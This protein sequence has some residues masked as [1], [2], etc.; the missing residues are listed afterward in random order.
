MKKIVTIAAVA[1][2]GAFLLPSC[3]KEYTCSCTVT[4]GGVSQTIEGKTSK[5]S[6]KDAKAQC[7]AGD[8]SSPAGTSEC[9]IK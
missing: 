5:L 2:F 9:E 1:L 8:Y 4:A 7:D 6:K 3:K